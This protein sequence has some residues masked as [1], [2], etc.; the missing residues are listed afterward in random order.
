M[1]I[2][3][4]ADPSLYCQDLHCSDISHSNAR[5]NH[6]LD[7]LTAVV[8]TTH[9]ILPTYGGCRVGDRRPGLSIPGWKGEV[10]PYRDSSLYWGDLWKANGRQTTGWIHENYKAARRQYHY[11]VLRAKHARHQHQAEQLLAASM[12]G[13]VHLLKEMKA[14]RK[15]QSPA[16]SE[17]PDNVGGADG[18]QAIAEMFR[19]SYEELFNSASSVPEMEEL[20]TTLNNKIG[21]QAKEEV[22]KINGRVVKEA[23]DK[24][25][26]KKTDVS[27]SFV[28]DALKGAPDI[29]FDQLSTVFRS[30]LYHG[31]ITKSLL[32]CSFIPLLKSSLK[33]PSSS[34]S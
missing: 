1:Q 13:E 18:E 6:V 11:A 4:G 5:D 32:A 30:W 14:I 8:E 16:N 25:K 3:R 10:K 33:D 19:N 23:I 29:M 24:L 34:D 15:N 22:V 21:P 28:S 17:L 20:K 9:S 12:S 2:G 27:G 31:T 26:L 7:I